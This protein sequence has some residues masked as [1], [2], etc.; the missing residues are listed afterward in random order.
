MFKK[1]LLILACVAMV[2]MAA[3]A[4]FIQPLDL[5]NT[6]D[7]VVMQELLSVVT[8]APKLYKGGTG[9]V[10]D[11]SIT[12][13][14]GGNGAGK[15]LGQYMVEPNFE[16]RS[17]YKDVAPELMCKFAYDLHEYLKLKQKDWGTYQRD[18]NVGF[19]PY[20]TQKEWA[21]T[22]WKNNH[23]PFKEMGWLFQDGFVY[24]ALADGTNFYNW[25]RRKDLGCSSYI[26]WEDAVLQSI[27]KKK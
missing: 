2:P 22:W 8:A 15:P 11:Y 18:P 1:L 17:A 10:F 7:A 27:C 9:Q 19:L 21:T 13:V 6:R 25:Y 23:K 20:E 16:F 24:D 26:A 12:G 4:Q 14:R 5:T 3:K